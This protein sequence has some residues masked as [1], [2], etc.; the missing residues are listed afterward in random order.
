[1]GGGGGG[2]GGGEAEKVLTELEGSRSEL[3]EKFLLLARAYARYGMPKRAFVLYQRLVEG[4][5]ATPEQRFEFCDFCLGHEEFAPEART[6][7]DKLCREG[8]LTASGYACLAEVFAA[9]GNKDEALGVLAKGLAA[10]AKRPD[11]T[12]NKEAVFTLNMAMSDL[13]HRAGQGHHAIA[14]SSTLKAMLAAPDLHFKQVLNDRLIT[15]LT[16]YGHRQKLLYTSEDESGDPKIFGGMRGAG[17]APWVDFL[18]TQANSREDTD[19]WMLLG[20]IHETVEVDAEL[21]GKAGGGRRIKTDLAQ[22][23]LCYEKVIDMEFQNLDSHRALARILADPAVDEYEK[24]INELEVISLLNPVT[25]WESM[26]AIGDLYALAG[27]MEK[28]LEKWQAVADQSASEPDLLGQVAM[29]MFRGGNLEAALDFAQR[30]AAMSP[31]VF[32]NRASYANLLGLLAAARPTLENLTRHGDEIA[33]ALKLALTSP[34]MSGFVPRLAHELFDS[35]VALARL[36]FVSGN[37]KAAKDQYDAT[38][39]LLKKTPWGE[40]GGSELAAVDV[41]VQLARCIEAMVDAEEAKRRYMDILRDKPTVVCW[42]SPGVTASGESFLTLK[43]EGRL[44]EGKAAV[45]RQSVGSVRATTLAACDVH[46]TVRDAV[47]NAAGE[48]Y[49]RGGAGNRYRVA[50]ADGLAVIEEKEWPVDGAGGGMTVLLTENAA[51]EGGGGRELR[52][53]VGG[54]VQ[55]RKKLSDIF[56]TT[57]SVLWYPPVLAGAMGHERV[58]L[59]NSLEGRIYVIDAR[60][61]AVECTISLDIEAISPP[62]VVGDVALV[63]ALRGG[64]VHV[65]A[66]DLKRLT[67]LYRTALRL[68]PPSDR[69]IGGLAESPMIW[70]RHAIYVD[71][72]TRQVV[73]LAVDTGEVSP[74]D[75]SGNELQPGD[76]RL[77]FFW[78]LGGDRLCRVSSKGQ[79]AMWRLSE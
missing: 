64:A 46:E 31:Y 18:N 3:P 59:T 8:V 22:A 48:L 39:E 27:E 10:C 52:T 19:L 49:V 77:R 35:R 71:P 43:R 75:L 79:I 42:L 38:V 78:R 58:L 51:G 33:E 73:S 25:K 30:T 36:Q 4:A 6:Q 9:R 67:I 37:F 76:Y 54:A 29:R 57:A 12:E 28:A 34:G 5:V 60:S 74:V 1:G 41:Q 68:P 11:G 45:V 69:V 56:G 50:G 66:I 20:Q 53:Y 44:V 7:A 15:L 65:A 23:R 17:I 72:Q 13:E 55:L 16:N 63:H 70:Q 2:G 14:I 24:A 26:Q 62:V 40:G 61:G 47:M 32:R 21:H